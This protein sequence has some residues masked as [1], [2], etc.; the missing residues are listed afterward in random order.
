MLHMPFRVNPH[1]RVARMLRNPS[2]EIGAVSETLVTATGVQR[3][4]A[5]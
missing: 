2:L 5:V 3:G 1:S 4:C